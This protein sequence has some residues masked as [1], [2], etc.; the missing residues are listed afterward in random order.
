MWRISIDLIKIFK[1]IFITKQ[2]KIDLLPPV[3]DETVLVLPAETTK[4]E[5]LGIVKD[6]KTENVSV[7][8]GSTLII[9]SQPAKDIQET[10]KEISEEKFDKRSV[11]NETELIENLE[12]KENTHVVPVITKENR[13]L[14]DL[15]Q[16]TTRIE[17]PIVVE[18]PR[19]VEAVV[20]ESLDELVQ[21][22]KHA[23]LA[24]KLGLRLCS[25]FYKLTSFGS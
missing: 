20:V 6:L 23:A 4:D 3:E 19:L 14:L 16:N 11:V 2:T 10:I 5:I 13:N 25:I 17:K 7:I 21:P 8:V 22:E 15:I 9:D 12:N 24:D 1:F 18:P